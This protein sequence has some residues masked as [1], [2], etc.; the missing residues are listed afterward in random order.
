M[1]VKKRLKIRFKDIFNIIVVQVGTIVGAGFATGNEIY[2]FFVRYGFF[3][4]FLIAVFFIFFFCF[5]YK[6]MLLTSKYN[7]YS[8]YELSKKV[9]GEKFAFVV[10]S[11]IYCAFFIF[12]S[13]MMSALNEVFGLI[14][15]FL[16]AIL[17]FFLCINEKKGILIANSIILPLIIIYLLLLLNNGYSL[18]AQET[19]KPLSILGIFGIFYY[20]SLNVIMSL[21]ALLVVVKNCSKNELLVSVLFSCFLL[22]LLIFIVFIILNKYQFSFIQMPLKDVA[23]SINGTFSIFANIILGCTIFTTF[24][25]S[26]FGIYNRLKFQQKHYLVYFIICLFLCYLLSLVGFSNLVQ[27]AYNTIGFI[28]LGVVLCFMLAKTKNIQQ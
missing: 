26:I 5:T 19:L 4:Y 14:G 13:V 21:G 2:I 23:Y 25:S 8:I 7:T 28:S 20:V 12:A 11:V 27:Y 22:S 24:L 10:N 1:K 15:V 6:I 9:F 3:G 18:S 16:M 17:G